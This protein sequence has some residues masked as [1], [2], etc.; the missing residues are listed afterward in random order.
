MTYTGIP[1]AAILSVELLKQSKFPQDSRL[2]IPRS[3]IIQNLSMFIGSLE[4]VRPSE[5]KWQPKIKN[6]S[7]N[8]KKAITYFVNA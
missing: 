5:G 3:E 8:P 1:S 2:A 7:L 6:L 4:W